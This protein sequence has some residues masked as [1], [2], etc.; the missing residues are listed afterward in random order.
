[1][2]SFHSAELYFPMLDDSEKAAENALQNGR[3]R[4]LLERADLD[5]LGELLEWSRPL[6]KAIVAQEMDPILRTKAD[7]SD[8]VQ[9]T[10]EDAVRSL[11]SLR[12]K[13]APQFLSWLKTL[14]I[15]NV[16]DVQRR[17]VGSQK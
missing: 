3:L 15:H 1:M 10:C 9:Q 13:T 12:A 11:S 14:L 2:L 6:M 5:S 17:F 7:S 4:D 16:V 8:I